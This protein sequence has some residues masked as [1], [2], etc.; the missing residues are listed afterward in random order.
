LEQNLLALV[1]HGF[2][3]DESANIFHER[4]L[5]RE[6]MGGV[7]EGFFGAVEEE[8]ERVAEWSVALGEDA[9]DFEHH[10]TW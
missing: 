5:S 9:C 7:L 8:D 6:G 4:M 2:Q 3:I 10:G 1:S